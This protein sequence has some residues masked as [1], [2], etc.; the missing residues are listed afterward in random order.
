MTD[1]QHLKAWKIAIG[2]LV[3]AVLVVITIHSGARELP[4][5]VSIAEIAKNPMAYDAKRVAIFT[6]T[7]S[8]EARVGR[9]GSNFI[10]CRIVKNEVFI[11]VCVTFPVYGLVG[12]ASIIQGI[13]HYQGWCG[14]KLAE[15]FISADTFMRDW[16]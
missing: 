3:V 9:L 13:Y 14:G 6:Y 10:F 2:T 1:A 7:R 8:C 5:S 15:N 16:G 11:S 12:N 4:L